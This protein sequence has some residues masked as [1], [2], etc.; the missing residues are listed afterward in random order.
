MS[1]RVHLEKDGRE[2]WSGEFDGPIALGRQEKDEPDPIVVVKHAEITR[3]V[4]AQLKETVIA[5]HQLSVVPQGNGTLLVQN[6]SRTVPVR[7]NGSRELAADKSEFFA[8]PV[9]FVVAST[10]I[11]LRPGEHDSVPSEI[12]LHSLANA[13]LAPGRASRLFDGAAIDTGRSITSSSIETLLRVLEVTLGLLNGSSTMDEFY[14][15]AAQALVKVL[16]F[17]VGRVLLWQGERWPEV[18]HAAA[19]STTSGDGRAA[20]RRILT[21]VLQDQSAVWQ[22]EHTGNAEHSLANI[23]SVLAVPILDEANQVVAVLYGERFFLATRPLTSVTNRDALVANLIAG[24]VASGLSRM[25][26]EQDASR[27]RNQFGQFFSAKLVQR[28]ETNPDMLNARKGE[29]SVLFCDIRKFSSIAEKLGAARLF[30]WIKDVLGQLSEC[31]T[32]RDGVL[33]D[34]I[35]DELMAMWGPP[36]DQQDHAVRACEAARDMISRIPALNARWI[37]E[38]NIPLEI[39]I[40]VNSGEVQVGNSGTEQKFK[41]GPLG[42]EVNL[43]SRVRGATKFLKVQALITASTAAKLDDNFCCRRLCDARV[44]NMKRQIRL[45]ELSMQPESQVASLHAQ[46]EEARLAFE[47]H[48]DFH[49]A[50][51]LLGNLMDR[52]RDDGPSQVLL[53]RAVAKMFAEGDTDTVWDLPGK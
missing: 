24:A 20:S 3:V 37:R 7:V 25:R 4:I 10:T 5:R 9:A 42:D 40:G 52:Y 31:V 13:T 8:M 43:A 34:Y 12:P 49:K 15:R 35:G 18:A 50:V 29:A 1:F 44:V 21:K 36:D 48:H 14:R 41:Y 30:D 17:D 51:R 16:G 32:A 33:V 47:E 27:L 46:Y 26:Y 19:E 6:T 28:L 2:V 38:T 39:S 45:Y 22:N 11:W 23:G 53:S